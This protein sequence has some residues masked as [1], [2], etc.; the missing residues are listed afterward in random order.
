ML[1]GKCGNARKTKASTRI[2]LIVMAVVMGA[3]LIFPGS[4]VLGL[5]EDEH[6]DLAISALTLKWKELYQQGK[7]G[8]GYLEIAH[9]RVL[10]IDA[11]DN[12]YLSSKFDKGGEIE[13]I[14]EFVL[15]SDYFRSAPY[16]YHEN[17]YDTVLI[18]K[19]GTA[20][21]M[22]KNILRLYSAATYK[23]DYSDFVKDIVNYGAAFNRTIA[24]Q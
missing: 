10:K 9:T 6:V 15:F 14:V 16:Y 20:S 17:L 24:I 13:Y 19:D 5:V 21:V 2:T 23:Y 1:C 3:F 7:A 11:S 12:A 22:Q 8:D 4:T 18:F